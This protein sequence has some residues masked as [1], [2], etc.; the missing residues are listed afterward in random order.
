MKNLQ[1]F[2]EFLDENYGITEAKSILPKLKI[3]TVKVG[4]M[5]YTD[6]KQ[7]NYVQWHTLYGG[8]RFY[9]YNTETPNVKHLV[10]LQ[11]FAPTHDNRMVAVNKYF[12]ENIIKALG[13]EWNRNFLDNQSRDLRKVLYVS[14]DSIIGAINAKYLK[15]KI[16]EMIQILKNDG[17]I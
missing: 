2:E 1:S 16:E 5:S 4:K 9:V 8:N 14:N 15:S 12:P 6:P 3:E 17:L 10:A 13:I 7:H 11:G